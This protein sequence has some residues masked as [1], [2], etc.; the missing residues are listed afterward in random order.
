MAIG[1]CKKVRKK[2]MRLLENDGKINLKKPDHDPQEN[3][4]ATGGNPLFSGGTS[5]G[6]YTIETAE[7]F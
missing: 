5:R 1:Y 4:R 6:R 7:N 2:E 3:H